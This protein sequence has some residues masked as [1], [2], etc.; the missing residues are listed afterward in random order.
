MM[1]RIGMHGQGFDNTMA[2]GDGRFVFESLTRFPGL[3]HGVFGRRGGVSRPPYDSLNTSY[4]V[5]DDPLRVSLNLSLVRAA[6]GAA[7]LVSMNQVH[8]TGI[9]IV[10]ADGTGRGGP[11]EADALVTSAPGMAIMAGLA[12]CQGIILYDPGRAAAAVVHCG[13][14]GQVSNITG[15]VVARMN[16]EFGCRPEDLYAAVSPSLGP[17]CAEFTSH[18]QIFPPYFRRFLVGDNRFDLWELSRFQL[19]EAGLSAGNVSIAGLCT[20]CRTDLFF[21]YRAEGQTGRFCAVAMLL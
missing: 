15:K 12:D 18:S 1:G 3:V 6:V 13:W 7:K 5:G 2:A 11:P 8:G 16:K 9:H 10:G 17:C 20:R 4:S 21:S 14:R 19:V